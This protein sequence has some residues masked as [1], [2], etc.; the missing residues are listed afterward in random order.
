MMASP[1]FRDDTS[2]KDTALGKRREQG[3]VPALLS[4]FSTLGSRIT[5]SALLLSAET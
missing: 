2:T 3:R 5:P 4:L 1:A